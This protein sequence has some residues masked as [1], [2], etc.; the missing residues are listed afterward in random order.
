MFCTYSIHDLFKFRFDINP[1]FEDIKIL[2][3]LMIDAGKYV[4]KKTGMSE[5]NL[6]M[7]M[8]CHTLCYNSI[9]TCAYS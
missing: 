3:D 4:H 8:S 5:E 2:N 9:R 6:F 7:I 1:T